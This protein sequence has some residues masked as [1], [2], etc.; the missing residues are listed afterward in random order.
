MVSGGAR[1]AGDVD[2]AGAKNS[3]LKLMAASLLAQG[4]T[5]LTNCPDIDDV[6]LMADVLTG[7]GCTVD[8]GGGRVTIDVP[9]ELSYAAD[10]P[11]VQ[12][13]AGLGGRA[14]AAD[15]AL[16][17]GRGRTAGR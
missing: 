5:V 12:P 15:G 13:A 4:T 8:I 3:V 10:F 11:A 1:L 6:P 17:A 9:A 14:G 16:P 2:V 7:L